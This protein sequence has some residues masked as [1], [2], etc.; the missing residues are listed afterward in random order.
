M[1][2]KILK[3]LPLSLLLL[4][5][6]VTPAHA[7][8]ESWS[9]VC[10]ADGTGYGAADG[11]ATIQGLQCL[12]A[13]LLQTAITI[14]GLL[15]FVMILYGGFKYLISGG[16]TKHTDS[17]RSTITYAIIG[18]VVAL[19]SIIILNLISSFTGVANITQFVIPDSS[20]F[21]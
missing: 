13:N 5:V 9:G 11:V 19:S 3:S 1:M 4:I 15:G 7:Q 2:K 20:V 14:L 17:A 10:V 16:N 6:L 12:I 21:H 18:I 8:T